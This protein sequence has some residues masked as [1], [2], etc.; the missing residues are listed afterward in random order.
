MLSFSQTQNKIQTIKSNTRKQENLSKMPFYIDDFG[1]KTVFHT[2]KFRLQSLED[3]AVRRIMGEDWSN[4]FVKI[5]ENFEWNRGDLVVEH[6]MKLPS[7]LTSKILEKF[8]R[9]YNCTSKTVR[10][11]CIYNCGESFDVTIK[12]RNGRYCC[13]ISNDIY[14]DDLIAFP[15]PKFCRR[16]RSE[17]IIDCIDGRLRMYEPLPE[18]WY[19]VRVSTDP[20]N[21]GYSEYLQNQHNQA[22]HALNGNGVLSKMNPDSS[23]LIS[24]ISAEVLKKTKPSKVKFSYSNHK[25]F[26]PML[27]LV[28]EMRSDVKETLTGGTE[29]K[30]G[31][32]NSAVFAPKNI[33]RVHFE[34]VWYKGTNVPMEIYTKYLGSLKKQ[35]MNRNQLIMSAAQLAVIRMFNIQVRGFKETLAVFWKFLALYLDLL[36]QTRKVDVTIEDAWEY[37]FTQKI[38]IPMA[39]AYYGS[40]LELLTGPND[41]PDEL[42]SALTMFLH[43]ENRKIDLTE[44]S[45]S[46]LIKKFQSGLL[47]MD[48]AELVVP[49][50]DFH[51]EEHNIP[52]R[53]SLKNYEM[54]EEETFLYRVVHTHMFTP[55]LTSSFVPALETTSSELFNKVMPKLVK[56]SFGGFVDDRLDTLQTKLP[57]VRFD[58]SDINDTVIQIIEKYPEYKSFGRRCQLQAQVLSRILG[59]E[60][61]RQIFNNVYFLTEM[62]K[63]KLVNVE[64]TMFASTSKEHVQEKK[65]LLQNLRDFKTTISTT[66]KNVS[67]GNEMWAKNKDKL[68][69][70]TERLDTTTLPAT[71]I[72][73]DFTTF[74]GSITAAK[75][76]VN[77]M[78]ESLL[79]TVMG[80]IGIDYEQYKPK[81]D[82]TTFFFYYLVWKDTSNIGIKIM[83]L[84]EVL[85]TLGIVD[86]FFAYMN[87]LW[88]LIKKLG[89]K[90]FQS[91]IGGNPAFEAYLSKMNQETNQCNQEAA[92]IFASTEDKD[93][94]IVKNSTFIETIMTYLEKGSPYFL[95][96]AA[97]LLLTSFAAGPVLDCSKFDFLKCGKEIIQSARNL[98]FLGAGLA[99]APKI[100]TNFVACFKWVIDQVKAITVK[101]HETEYEI[102]SRAEKWIVST[103]NYSGNV[104]SRLVRAPQLCLT[105]LSLYNE[106]NYLKRHDLRFSPKVLALFQKRCQQ[107]EP[108]FE[109][110]KS[111]MYS[112]FCME[113]MFH[114]QIAGPPGVGKTDLSDALLRVLKDAYA[115]SNIDFGEAVKG[116]SID[117]LQ[118]FIDSGIKF[119][120]VYNMNPT[121]KHMDAYEG[122]R[123]IRVDDCN[124]FNNPEPDAVTT[125]IL[126]LS[127]TCTIANKASLNTKG[128]PITAKAQISAT[129]NPFLKPDNMPCY[130]ALWRRRV[131]LQVDVDERFKKN[132]KMMQG[133]EL[134]AMFK[135]LNLN[136]T[137]G[138]HLLISVMDPEVEGKYL[139]TDPPNALKNLTVQEALTYINYRAKNHYAHEWQRGM[140]KDPYGTAIKVKFERLL[141]LL[142][143]D[144]DKAAP[145]TAA[146]FSNQISKIVQAVLKQREGLA[147]KMED[148]FPESSRIGLNKVNKDEMKSEPY[149]QELTAEI[150]SMSEYINKY[151][152]LDQFSDSMTNEQFEAA[153]GS[154]QT[155]GNNVFDD[156]FTRNS[157]GEMELIEQAELKKFDISEVLVDN[158]K[159]SESRKRYVSTRSQEWFE[160]QGENEI[161]QLAADLKYLNNLSPKSA[162]IFLNKARQVQSTEKSPLLTRLKVDIKYRY[163]LSK[164]ILGESF[165]FLMDKVCQYIGKPLITALCITVTLFGVFFTC[166][167]IG[168]LLAPTP[169][170]YNKN[171]KP[172]QI[173][174]FG[175]QNTISCTNIYSSDEEIKQHYITNAQS[176]ERQ[177]VIV[178]MGDSY[179]TAVGIKGNIFMINQHCAKY[180]TKNTCLQIFDPTTGITIDQWVS[181]SD[182][183]RIRLRHETD[184][185]LIRFNAVRTKK[186]I[187]Q[188][189]MTEYDL[190]NNMVNLRTSECVPVIYRSGEFIERQFKPIISVVPDLSLVSHQRLFGTNIHVKKGESGSLFVHNNSMLSGHILGLLTSRNAFSDH[191]Y[192]GVISKEEI[193]HTL[194][195]F[196]ARDQ[197]EVIP[198]ELQLDKEHT[199]N[200]IFKYNQ[201]VKRS[202]LPSQTISSTLGFKPTPIYGCVPVET[203]PAIQSESDPRWNKTRHFLEVS[204]NKTS[205][206]HYAKFNNVEEVWM[207]DFYRAL[208]LQYCP[209]LDKVVLYNTQQAIM[210][211]R[212]PGSTAMELSTCAGLPY[213]LQRG[214]KG[215]RPFIDNDSRGAYSIQELVFQ[216]VTR[217]EQSYIQGVVP[218]NIKLEF[219]KKELVG[220]NKIENPKTRTVGMGNMI[221][222][223]VYMK[224]R[225][226]LHTMLKRV[227]A[228]GGSM[229]FALGVDP[230]SEH[231]NQIAQHLK[232]HDYMVDMDVK[233]WEEK[234]SQRLLFMCDEVE[235]DLI[236][237]SYVARGE[238]FP[239]ETYNIAYGLSADYTQSDVAFQ[240][241]IYEKPSGLL[242]GHPGTFMVNSA[243]HAMIIG[244]IARRILLRKNPQLASIPYIIENVRFVLAADDVVISVS[245]DAR[246]HITIQDIVEGYLE[247]GFEV[248]AADKSDKI[249]P[250]TIEQIQFLK[251]DFNINEDG[252]ITSRPNLS[253]IYQLINWYSTESS[254]T[255][256]QQITENFDNALGFA[257]QRGPQ[258]YE[259]IRSLI[260]LACKKVRMNYTNVLSYET[261]AELLKHHRA[262]AQAAFYAATPE[263][264]EIDLDY[265]GA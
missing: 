45:K 80:W 132:G 133:D 73:A 251:H 123:F 17:Y 208:L 190:Q 96:V 218:Q 209:N 71:I 53:M 146:E 243:I 27:R 168:Q 214:V 193:E 38:K 121:L 32:F 40:P 15:V 110:V 200:T 234:V 22:T 103:A 227:W 205:G 184:A 8:E 250:K 26:D 82:F 112:N 256:E 139:H 226:D 171:P 199:V 141:E 18:I 145:T 156:Y 197:I 10:T 119:G 12:R 109:I 242:S 144:V 187:V 178:T 229:P 21:D 213:K 124:L 183:Q 244:L 233:A 72:K 9:L 66:L 230:A 90:V 265:V 75:S 42:P 219:N 249:L 223:I 98:S 195:K 39:T 222:Q 207:K 51:K 59:F 30:I 169:T 92:N 13:L 255:K 6:M 142:E 148:A 61:P 106:M 87:K 23:N 102:N 97:T 46:D 113:E 63:L 140:E 70:L 33:L 83:I 159:Y 152:E 191:A 221:H 34:G 247:A 64:P 114:V 225:K 11:S 116:S 31:I 129:N 60:M 228:D 57:A 246:Q 210:G 188:R 2:N 138:D 215:K 252:F 216:E 131:L 93:E 130:K 261:R 206:A 37:V 240:D 79:K 236:K 202:F 150:A 135:K 186:T 14:P 81:I 47:E 254:L 16:F 28:V 154:Q 25:N 4:L 177:T 162:E 160:N 86:T 166:S 172:M 212:I 253:I 181:P 161:L 120:D 260:N 262:Q 136:R 257:W 217:Y 76:I 245:P 174:G 127:G 151:F 94:D 158:I 175:H 74:S 258:E 122:Q 224:T 65:G 77:N 89:S 48:S 248:T 189:F 201:V 149:V 36:K 198:Y 232:Y 101:N 85:S 192:I 55:S 264:D 54:T 237:E 88:T 35:E 167:L 164:Q 69:K 185:V 7:Q 211:V 203:T 180:I 179:F 95:G 173:F 43:V 128:Q 91:C 238:Q 231:W 19:T 52:S 44:V 153:S 104:A 58:S 56:Y 29:G 118:Q 111:V 147:T 50:F 24:T 134:N 125:Q 165:K 157:D 194:A 41:Y 115:Q 235:I 100:Y 67:E 137:K 163:E 5:G 259:R 99:A 107:F 204:L 263:I 117:I 143:Q 126:M 155:I 176:L 239:E 62:S 108:F 84:V 105:Y 170:M 182:I 3:L 78:F 196:N 241:F 20:S 49:V 68:L 220:P 1:Y